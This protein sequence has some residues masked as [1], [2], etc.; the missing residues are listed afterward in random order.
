VLLAERIIVLGPNP[1]KVRADFRV[2]LPQ[3]RERNSA[4]FL[5]YVDYIYK[6]MT[7]PELA[8]GPPSALDHDTKKPY[9]M[10]P[11]RPGSIVTALK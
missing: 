3:P 11:T 2:P 1:A 8:A 5:L 7:Q 4:E 6:L 9:G 10:P